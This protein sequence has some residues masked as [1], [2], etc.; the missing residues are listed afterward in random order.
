MVWPSSAS[1][2]I[3]CAHLLYGQVAFLHPV[4]IGY[5]C[6]LAL[7]CQGLGN[8]KDYFQYGDYSSSW[9]ALSFSSQAAPTLALCRAYSAP[10]FFSWQ[11][12]KCKQNHPSGFFIYEQMKVQNE[13]KRKRRR[14]G[15]LKTSKLKLSKT[16]HV[17]EWT[18]CLSALMEHGQYLQLYQCHFSTNMSK[19]E[20]S[21]MKIAVGRK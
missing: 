21:E 9:I 7:T 2:W 15:Y 8:P 12:G 6:R 18:A 16:S 11:V 13:K 1:W 20:K 19:L 14:Q 4:I 10:T 5:H 17:L 3:T